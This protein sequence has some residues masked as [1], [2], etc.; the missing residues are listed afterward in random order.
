M[1]EMMQAYSNPEREH[2]PHALPDIEVFELTAREAVELDEDLMWEAGKRFPLATFN[3]RDHE[4]AIDWA[5]QESKATSGWYWW[6]CYPGCLPDSPAMGPFR[7]PAEAL[8]DAR[9]NYADS[10][11]DAEE[12][13][14]G[15]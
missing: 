6:T 10:F 13:D 8:A 12:T 7:T 4:K 15:E 2:D 14:G 5:V 9:T 1:E 11:P 3:S